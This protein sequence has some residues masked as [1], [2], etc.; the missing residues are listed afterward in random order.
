MRSRF[1]FVSSAVLKRILFFFFLALSLH[2]PL[3]VSAQ[4]SSSSP[5]SRYGLGDLQYTGFANTAAMGG[6]SYAYQNDSIAPFYINVNNPASLSKTYLTTF[7][8]GVMDRLTRMETSSQTYDVN[9]TA[10]SHIAFAFPVRK[11]W[12]ASFGIMPF[13]NV[14]YKV[15][16]SEYVPNVGNVC[17]SYQGSG[18]LNEI[19]LANGISRGNLSFGATVSYLF[20]ALDL[21]SRDSFPD[22]TNSWSTRVNESQHFNDVYFKGGLQYKVN[23][24][25]HWTLLL[26]LTANMQTQ[27]TAHSSVL[28]MTYRYRFSI[29]QSK[30][31]AQYIAD[32]KESVTLPAMYGFGIA[33]RKGEKLYINADYSMQNWSSFDSFGQKGLLGN[34]NRISA[35]FQYWPDRNSNKGP[36]YKKMAYRAGAR[37][38]NTY[39]LL[40]QQTPLT[41]MAFTFGFGMPLRITKVGENYNQAMLNLSF[42]L[43]QRGTIENNLIRENYVR[44]VLGFSINEKW[45]IQR[46]YD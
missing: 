14:G 35:G 28:A 20:G 27:L 4:T 25:K 10:L 12:G 19:F 6:V 24:R 13:S 30:D 31:T 18:G 17:Y 38:S 34:S 15:N 41:D 44:V 45:F 23:M 42:E 46:K 5:Y 33:L 26:G 39:L 37:F 3:S 29:D 1:S 36:Y 9:R 43:G 40:G 7:D 8:V 16:T 22:L 21:E 2:H 11:W 32:Q